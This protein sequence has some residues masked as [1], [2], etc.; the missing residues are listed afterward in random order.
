MCDVNCQ[1]VYAGK[2]NQSFCDGGGPSQTT[3]LSCLTRPDGPRHRP[4]ANVH[5]RAPC[6]QHAQDIR[7]EKHDGGD[8]QEPEPAQLAQPPVL[9]LLSLGPPSRLD[10]GPIP[11]GPPPRLVLAVT[12]PPAVAAVFRAAILAPVA[13]VGR[14]A[15]VVG[16]SRVLVEVLRE[17]PSAAAAVIEV[18]AGAAR[19]T[20]ATGEAAAAAKGSWSAA[21]HHAEEDIGVDV[22]AHAAAEHVGRVGQVHAAVVALTLPASW[23]VSE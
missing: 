14:V 7:R 15:L 5:G 2:D 16:L 13:V 19:E 1:L 3:V 11:A 22:A 21:A 23:V 10:T 12:V 6:H 9:F 4:H 8:N 17:A 18:E 20:A